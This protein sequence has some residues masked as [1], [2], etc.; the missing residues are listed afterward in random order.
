MSWPRYC[1][2]PVIFT[3]GIRSF[4]RS[5]VLRKVDLP[6]PE[7]PMR[8]VTCFSGMSISTLFS[9]WADPYHR[10]RPRAER[11]IVS[12]IVRAPYFF[13]NFLPTRLAARLMTRVMAMRTTA[14][15][16]ARSKSARTLA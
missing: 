8:A 16:K 12:S 7:G 5:R 6:Q 1:T 9:A 13:F 11:M 14:T 4:I 10:S 3:P 2:E 15:E